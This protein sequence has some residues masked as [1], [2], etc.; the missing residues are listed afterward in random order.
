MKKLNNIKAVIFD[1]A[2]TIIDYGCMAPTQVFI[3][4]FSGKGITLSIEEARGPMG[5]AKKDHVRELMRLDSVQKQWIT[6]FGQI[7]A[8][9]DIEAIYAELEPSLA[10]VVKNF[11]TPIPGAVELINLLKS[12]D[13]KVGTTTGYVAE[14]MNNIL[15]HALASGLIPDSVV[16]S[17]DVSAGRPFPWMIYR[18][19]EKLNV[20]PLNQMVKI[21]DTVADIQEGINAGM[22]TI[23]L[24]KSGN[25]LGL[26]LAD[27]G[28]ADPVWLKG[29]ITLA[30]RKLLD[31]GA[32][33]VAEGVWD[34]LP[35][36]EE[37]NLQIESGHFK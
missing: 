25:E 18:N 9:T 24:T 37:I 4:V 21:G 3:E 30:G 11:S 10:M 6:K 27:T 36:L 33:F 7:P 26:S 32:D 8:E 35:V 28:K 14:M 13:V 20:Y 5:Q 29:K 31:A 2:G 1:W 15:P 19:C 23:G 22:W 16:N 34:C 17:S 12:H